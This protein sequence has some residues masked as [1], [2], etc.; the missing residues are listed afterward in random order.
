M[1]KSQSVTLVKHHWSHFEWVNRLDWPPQTTSKGRRQQ[2]QE[3]EELPLILSSLGFPAVPPSPGRLITWLF[4]EKCRH[5]IHL[6]YE[7]L[8][9]W[10]KQ[11][12]KEVG[13]AKSSEHQPKEQGQGCWDV[14]LCIST[15]GISFSLS[16]HFWVLLLRCVLGAD[17]FFGC[18]GMFWV[19]RYFLGAGIRWFW[20]RTNERVQMY[21]SAWRHF[22]ILCARRCAFSAVWRSRLDI[23]NI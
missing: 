22:W 8:A 7:D 6:E 9:L 20:C 23:W 10:S 5:L 3:G 18:W 13:N 14:H 15:R 17:I 4:N 11:V 16:H 2:L 21:A 19:L 1:A 12:A